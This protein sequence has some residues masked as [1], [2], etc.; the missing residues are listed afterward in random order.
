[1]PE[2]GANPSNKR[3]CG[4]IALSHHPNPQDNS[5]APEELPQRSCSRKCKWQKQAQNPRRQTQKKKHCCDRNCSSKTKIDKRQQSVGH[6]QEHFDA[7]DPRKP[8]D[9]EAHPSNKRS[10]EIIA[11]SHKNVTNGKP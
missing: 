2:T 8:Y 5:I 3:P 11:L 9:R 6:E 4:I 10:A 1:M 7:V